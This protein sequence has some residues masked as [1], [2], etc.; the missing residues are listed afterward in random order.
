MNQAYLTGHGY[1]LPHPTILQENGT[2]DG[3][4]SP[5]S[6]GSPIPSPASSFGS[7][8]SPSSLYDSLALSDSE[9]YLSPSPTISDQHFPWGVNHQSSDSLVLHPYIASLSSNVPLDFLG[10]QTGPQRPR[11]ASSPSRPGPVA[12]KA[13]LEANGRRRRHP[14]QFVCPDCGQ[15][16]TALFSLKREFS[17]ILLCSFNPN[18]ATS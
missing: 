14:A 4:L 2:T 7:S 12:S 3:G 18:D 9:S 16:F 15:T 6:L 10:R 8:L 13:M 5:S 11:S 1:S 17:C